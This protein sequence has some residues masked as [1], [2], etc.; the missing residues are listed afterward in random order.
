MS[1][2]AASL[3]ACSAEMEIEILAQA[4]DFGGAVLLGGAVGLLYD[5]MRVFRH[6]L[7]LP[8]LGHVLDAVF[9][10]VVTVGLF[11]YALTAGD[12]RVRIFYVAAAAIGCLGYALSLS[13]WVR[14]GLDKAADAVSFLWRLLCFP[15]KRILALWKKILGKLKKYFQS[16]KNGLQ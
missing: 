11:V 14:M 15:I 13:R 16:A 3:R 12:G 4:V 6:R 10:L 1:A 5:G 7:G 2:A 9:W 8:W